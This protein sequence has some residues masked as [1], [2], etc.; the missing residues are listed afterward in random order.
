MLPWGTLEWVWKQLEVSP[1]N[2]TVISD[3]M[4]MR[5]AVFFHP[6]VQ[7]D[8]QTGMKMMCTFLDL[9]VLNAT[10]NIV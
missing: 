1:F 2:K 3:L 7:R 8:R 5:S 10:R 4:K 6:C 9:T